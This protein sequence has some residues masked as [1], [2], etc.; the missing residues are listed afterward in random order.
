MQYFKVFILINILLIFIPPDSFSQ[1][2]D[3]KKKVTIVM[4]KKALSEVLTEIQNKAGIHFSYNNQTIDT[5]KK[6][7]IVA[8][9][10]SIQDIFKILFSEFNIEYVLIEKQVVLK[11]KFI[12]EKTKIIKERKSKRHTISGYIKNETDDEVL[13]GA[14]VIIQ[15]AYMGTMTNSYGFYS[16]TLPQGKYVLNYSYIGFEDIFYEIDLKSDMNISQRMK[17][18][19]TE[20]EI[21]IITEEESLNAFEK[22]PLKK[23]K[24][25]EQMI[26]S[27][28]GLAG[29]ADVVKSIQSIPGINAYG[30]GS[31]LFYVRGGGKD[32]NLIMIDDVPIYNPSHL[33]GFFS[34]I[35]PDAINDIKIYKN[36]FPVKYGGRLSSV[37]DINTK[38]GSLKK[39]GFSGKISPLIGSYT[40][41]GPIRKERSSYLISL[42]NSQINWLFRRN[43]SDNTI[44]FNDFHVK[45]N[46]RINRNNRL[47]L[48]LYSGTDLLKINLTAFSSSALSWQNNI[49]SLRWNHLYSDRLFS[50]TTLH[51]SKYDYFLYHDYENNQYWNSFIGNLSLKNDFSYYLNPDNSMNFGFN[52]NTYF[53]NPGN[54]NNTFFQR[55][56]YSGNVLEYVLYFGNEFKLLPKLNLSYG[57]RLINWNNIGPTTVFSFDENYQVSDT[58]EYGKGSFNSFINTEPQISLSYTISKSFV[59]KISYDRHIQYLQLLSNSVSP[60]TTTDVWMPAG[61][62]MKPEKSHQFVFGLTKFFTEFEVTAETYYKKINS[63]IEFND[64]SNLLLNPF[65]EGELRFGEG[66]SYGLELAGQK[67]KGSFT[68]YSAYSYSRVFSKIKEING[69]IVFPARHDRPHNFSINMSYATEKRWSFNLNWMYSSGMRFSSPTGFFIYKGNQVP[70]YSSKN[71]DKLPDYHRLDVSVK[72]RLN[73]NFNRRYLHDLSL[74]IFNLYQRE[75]IIAVNFNKIEGINN[76]IYIPTNYISENDMII[77]SKSLLGMIPSITYSFKFR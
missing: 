26:N 55:T 17:I 14:G 20:L 6:V 33:F 34:A 9:R 67:K 62:N 29:E 61:L 40:I 47:Y 32:Q 46:Q 31:V 65:I 7:S 35:A 3:L 73:R 45:F 43:N 71:N 22:S 30:D 68:F 66:Y 64:H 51:T 56:V 37:V 75:N 23:T 59:S 27:N 21:V 76:E 25:T 57:L 69:G 41:D 16:L 10:K 50:N 1:N 5:E 11:K 38:N 4:K 74:S 28:V 18:D 13:I 52:I 72:F 60:F 36:N 58:T 49:I 44:N 19:E 42:R 77:T 15:K 53:F 8:R 12:V 48:S 54:L 24:L 70:I 63:M 2:I 39:F